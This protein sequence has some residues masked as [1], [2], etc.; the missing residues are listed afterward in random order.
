[1][2]SAGNS[3]QPI[4]QADPV[5][6]LEASRD[7]QSLAD[8][9]ALYADAFL[10]AEAVATVVTIVGYCSPP[11]FPCASRSGWLARMRSA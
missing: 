8:L 6:Y 3:G 9:A 2:L 5:G 7:Y 10:G 11:P 1:M 4:Y